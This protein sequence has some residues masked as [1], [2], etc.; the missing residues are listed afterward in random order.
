MPKKIMIVDDELHIVKY[1]SNIFTDQGYAVCAAPDGEEAFQMLEKE[2]PDL[3]TLDLQM[4]HEAG[5]KFYMRLRENVKYKDL[6]IVVISGMSAPH[7]AIKKAAAV[8]NKPFEPDDL[9]E[10]IKGI[11]GPAE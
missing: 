5:P 11:I 4:P 6:P 3:V 7:K 9:V 8:V 10:T 2:K 1:L